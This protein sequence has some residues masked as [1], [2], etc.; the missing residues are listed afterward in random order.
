MISGV[1]GSVCLAGESQWEGRDIWG[2]LHLSCYSP[3]A[4]RWG[5]LRKREGTRPCGGIG[6]FLCLVSWFGQQSC[7]AGE[8]GYWVGF[9]IRV[10]SDLDEM[11]FIDPS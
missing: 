9:A 3:L 4:I 7:A 6:A 5:G 8:A 1:S 2:S 10:L 11:V